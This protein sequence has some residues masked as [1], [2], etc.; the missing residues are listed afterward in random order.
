MEAAVK[1]QSICAMTSLC[2]KLR[3]PVML[4]LT[5]MLPAAAVIGKDAD[6]TLSK[7]VGDAQRLQQ[8]DLK[9]LTGCDSPKVSNVVHQFLSGS[10]C[11]AL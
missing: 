7:V 1:L 3:L 10:A 2:W 5:A 9:P 8:G 6:H 4:V 11:S